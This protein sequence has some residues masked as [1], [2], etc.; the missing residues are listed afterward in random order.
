MICTKEGKYWGKKIK[1]RKNMAERG[2]EKKPEK[3]FGQ[4]PPG[5]MKEFKLENGR[6]VT[7]NDLLARLNEEYEQDISRLKG[8]LTGAAKGKKNVALSAAEDE[9][10]V[11]GL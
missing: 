9:M 3:V 5:A 10:L 11:S 6:L 4:L 1:Y 8:K 7:G 2:N